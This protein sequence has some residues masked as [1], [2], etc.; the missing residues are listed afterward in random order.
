MIEQIHEW[1]SRPLDLYDLIAVGIGCWVGGRLF[2]L[3]EVIRK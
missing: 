1:L 2:R 3:L